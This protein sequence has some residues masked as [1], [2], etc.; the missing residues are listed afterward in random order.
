[1]WVRVSIRVVVIRPLKLHVS[2]ERNITPIGTVQR[3]AFI[4]VCYV[5]FAK[6]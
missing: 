4:I 5:Q 1:M 3:T 2:H 6:T